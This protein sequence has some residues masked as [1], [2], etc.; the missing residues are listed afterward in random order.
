MSGWGKYILA[1][2]GVAVVAH[3][4]VIIATPRLLMSVAF[5]RL[6]GDQ[7]PNAW[8]VAPRVTPDAR[9]IVRP[10]P[11]FAYSACPYDLGPG[12]LTLRVAP[13]RAYWSLSLYDENS[14]N[15]FT[16]NDRESRQGGNLTLVRGNAGD[17]EGVIVQSPTRRGIALIRRLAP[18]PA[19]YEEAVRVAADDVC[20]TLAR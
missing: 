1:A 16:L 20:A 12:P 5:D 14:D 4:A 19:E 8:R 17:I 15:F 6:S 11:D 9:T 7:P 2:V 13:W 10:S 3:L 18:T